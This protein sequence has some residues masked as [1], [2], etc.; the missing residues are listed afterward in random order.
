MTE[1]EREMRERII[2]RWV[3]HPEILE[4]LTKA[5]EEVAELWP[6]LLDDGKARE[7]AWEGRGAA[8]GSGEAPEIGQGH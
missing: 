1:N 2:R 7:G 8:I 5:L 4:R 6:S 3:E